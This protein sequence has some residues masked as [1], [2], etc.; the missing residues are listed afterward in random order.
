MMK[1]ELLKEIKAY[2]K[3]AKRRLVCSR[4]SKDDFY[5]DILASAE[6]YLQLHPNASKEELCEY[7]GD[8]EALASG[9][10]DSLPKSE[11]IR[12]RRKSK[13]L[14]VGGIVLAALILMLAFYFVAVHNLAD[15]QFVVN[16][17]QLM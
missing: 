10:M 11:I 5:R 14:L 1:A 6:E 15:V 2:L 4:K 16:Q 17:G 8:S 12:A 9:F 3:P 13:L 7:L